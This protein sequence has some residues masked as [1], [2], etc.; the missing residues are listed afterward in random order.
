MV[1]SL[2]LLSHEHTLVNVVASQK[3]NL[4][5]RERE[6]ESNPRHLFSIIKHAFPYTATATCPWVDLEKPELYLSCLG[7][8]MLWIPRLLIRKTIQGMTWETPL[9]HCHPSS[10]LSTLCPSILQIWQWLTR[11]VSF[12]LK[13]CFLGGCCLCV[14]SNFHWSDIE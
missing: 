3:W 8:H 7:M 14:A 6:R 12:L 5:E 1:H 4:K 2:R 13:L 11:H 10:I 9:L